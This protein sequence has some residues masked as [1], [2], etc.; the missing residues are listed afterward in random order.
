MPK[1]KL[2]TWGPYAFVRHPA[3][4]GSLLVMLGLAFVN[5]TPGSWV[6]ECGV[7]GFGSRLVGGLVGMGVAGVWY[8]WWVWVGVYRAELEDGELRK[9][10][11]KEWDVYARKVRWWFVPGVF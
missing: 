7:L 6:S 8:A 3:Y 9:L 5:L 2:I 4:S 11:G 1:H 10:F